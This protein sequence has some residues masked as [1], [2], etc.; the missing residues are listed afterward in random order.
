MRGLATLNGD[1][2]W[3]GRALQVAFLKKPSPPLPDQD[4][5]AILF[6]Y[7]ALRGLCL[8]RRRT[9]DDARRRLDRPSATW[10]SPSPSN[11]EPGATPTARIFAPNTPQGTS[12]IITVVGHLVP[13]Q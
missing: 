9:R 11:Y 13:A 10:R 7:Y 2:K 1:E 6:K 4:L 3:N 8:F 12:L 5:P